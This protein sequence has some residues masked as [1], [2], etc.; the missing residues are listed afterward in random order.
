MS[1]DLNSKFLAPDQIKRNRAKL[2]LGYQKSLDHGLPES[3]LKLRNPIQM[4][5]VNS[6]I[7]YLFFALQKQVDRFLIEETK[8]LK[9]EQEIAKASCPYKLGSTVYVGED[10]KLFLVSSI[11]Y[12]MDPPHYLVWFRPVF[13]KKTFLVGPEGG[14]DLK[15]VTV[16]NPE[17]VGE[18]YFSYLVKS[19]K[20][21]Y[22]LNKTVG[23][24]RRERELGEFLVATCPQGVNVVDWVNK[25]ISMP[26]NS[27]KIS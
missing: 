19:G 7:A 12:Q 22:G 21:T 24:Y 25:I 15:S 6:H 11:N 26:R 16:A 3:V 2:K 18:P 8:L 1:R 17:P 20:I 27:K 23:D 14:V 5:Y 13:S 4:D 10:R 9:I